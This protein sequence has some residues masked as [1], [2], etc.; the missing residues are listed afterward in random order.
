MYAPLYPKVKAENWWLV[1]GDA[2][3]NTCLALKRITLESALNVR[4]LV[5]NRF[6]VVVVVHLRLWMPQVKLEFAAPE[7]PGAHAYSLYFMSDSYMGCDQVYDFELNV[8]G[9][10]EVDASMD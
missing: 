6:V 2:K 10:G 1:V 5:L 4:A 8:T 9:G 3:A 7:A